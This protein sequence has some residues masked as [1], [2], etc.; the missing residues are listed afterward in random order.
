MVFDWKRLIGFGILTYIIPTTTYT[1]I[2]KTF[3]TI[4]TGIWPFLGSLLLLSCLLI[5]VVLYLQK[6]PDTTIKESAILATIWFIMIIIFTIIYISTIQTIVLS[7]HPYIVIIP[8][9]S[10][11]LLP[12]SI[13]YIKEK[14][15][16][17]A[18]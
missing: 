9:L 11:F 18:I 12:T 2:E 5:F 4:E 6:N 7:S 15:G 10:I 16:M 13:T 1:I 17:G 8:Y 14:I 3:P